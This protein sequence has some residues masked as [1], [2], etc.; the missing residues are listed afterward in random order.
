MSLAGIGTWY[1]ESK[2]DPRWNKSGRG[3]GAATAGGPPEMH[4]W[5]ATCKTQYGTPPADAV[6][7][8]MKD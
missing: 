5:I 6:M 2:S 3:Y 1:V 7:G 4:E 8:F